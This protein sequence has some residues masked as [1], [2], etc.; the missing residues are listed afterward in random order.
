MRLEGVTLDGAAET[1]AERQAQQAAALDQQRREAEEQ[2]TATA[3]REA[4]LLQDKHDA[5]AAAMQ[6]FWAE[7]AE[8]QRKRQLDG[9]GPVG[10]KVA[11]HTAVPLEAEMRPPS[12]AQAG[13]DELGDRFFSGTNELPRVAIRLP[14][15]FCQVATR[16]MTRPPRAPRTPRRLPARSR[17]TSH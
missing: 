3:Q 6:I 11:K 12:S 1:G 2:R 14:S 8:A 4:K 9:P 7:R 17:P 16:R 5:E 13:I 15:D 10:A